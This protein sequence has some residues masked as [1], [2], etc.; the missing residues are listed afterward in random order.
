MSMFNSPLLLGFDHFERVLDRVSKASAEGYP[1][2]NIEQ[3]GEHDLRITLA[4]AGFT[5]ADLAVTVEDNQLVVRGRH[6]VPEDETRIFLH[7]GIAA[8]QFQRSF[9]L[10]EG[11][12]VKGARLENG[13]LHIDLARPVPETVVRR[14]HIEKAP[15][16]AAG[17]TVEAPA[18]RTRKSDP[19]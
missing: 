15:T 17:R 5:E 7:R 2:Y 13:L 9:V 6:A 16:P 19:S 14:I 18:S 1:P 11:I 10:A 12:E 3:T 4:V 8:R